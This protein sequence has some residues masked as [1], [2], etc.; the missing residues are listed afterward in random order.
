M[1]S[2][3]C[4]SHSNPPMDIKKR[5]IK[6]NS[7]KHN[8][9]VFAILVSGDMSEFQR[10]KIAE[11]KRQKVNTPFDDAHIKVFGR[12]I[13]CPRRGIFTWWQNISVK[14]DFG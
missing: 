12:K 7:T 14:S 8:H 9:S 11:A 10:L 13:Y 6:N 2:K 1:T 3:A 4:N 5:T